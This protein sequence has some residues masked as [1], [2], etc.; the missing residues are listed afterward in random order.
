MPNAQWPM[1]NDSVLEHWALSIEPCAGGRDGD[2][3]CGSLTSVH[4]SQSAPTGLQDESGLKSSIFVNSS[5]VPGPR[6]FSYTTP[7]LLT[8]NVFTPVTPYL[9]GA[10]TSAKPPIIT[11][12]TT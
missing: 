3:L 12:F 4:P 5:S 6:S 11:P 8:M 1:S 2:R 7:S 10:A 9:A